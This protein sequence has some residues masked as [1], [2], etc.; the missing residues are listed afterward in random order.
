MRSMLNLLLVLG[1]AASFIG[2][3]APAR[4]S[5][6]SDEALASAGLQYYWQME[7]PLDEGVEIQRIQ[8]IDE[9]LYCLTT[10][11][12]LIVVDA[13]RGVPLWSC[14]A[15]KPGESIFRP[16]HADAMDLSVS[17]P[18]V[19]EI[20]GWQASGV[21]KSVDVVFLN[22]DNHVRVL[23]RK[24]GSEYRKID[25]G[26]STNTG[27]VSDGRHFFVGA[28]NG[29]Y[30]ALAV[31]EGLEAWSLSTDSLLSARPAFFRG[32]LFVGGEDRRLYCAE[33]GERGNEL[34]S[35]RLDGAVTC[36]FHVDD[37]GCFVPCMDKHLYAF[38]PI[39]GAKLWEPFG[40]KA[41]LNAGVEVGENSVFLPAPGD[42]LYAINLANGRQ[43]WHVPEG[44]GVLAV[45]EGNVYVLAK[46]ATLRVM[47]EMLGET[48][49]SIPLGG[50]DLFA[51]NT[52]SSGVFASTR[53]GRVFCI[54]R[55][56]AGR[57][58]AEMLQNGQ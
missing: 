42:G 31:N 27:G 19:G 36:A 12:Q 33:T 17:P 35:R 40:T 43:R 13:A 55:L 49:H 9:N 24:D 22:T 30:Y 23:D 58:T 7:L 52:S 2:C 54:R 20:G 56:E 14:Q 50:L 25:F 44:R 18:G 11:D 1:T 28:T 6:A 47:D 21:R 45:I 26:F 5:V 16:S 46:D 57:L 38:D 41:P 8:L 34:W 32:R 51:A 4:P 48:T 15:A 53:D 3:A 29:R 10:D 37:R 39:S